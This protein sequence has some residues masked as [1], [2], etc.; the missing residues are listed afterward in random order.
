MRDIDL[1]MDYQ[2]KKKVGESFD[3]SPAATKTGSRAAGL[4]AAARRNINR[5]STMSAELSFRFGAPQTWLSGFPR[6]RAPLELVVLIVLPPRR[7][8]FV[9][10]RRLVK[11]VI[12]FRCL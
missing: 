8:K 12:L 7:P 1:A 3:G 6:S 10:D 11:A 2:R 4:E 9:K 5:E